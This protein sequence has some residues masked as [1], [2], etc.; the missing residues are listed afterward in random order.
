M[1]LWDDERFVDD[2]TLSVN[3]GRLRKKLED[4]GLV[5]KIQTLRGQGYQLVW[6]VEK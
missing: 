4:M 5:D 2:N 6:E 1:K 3:M